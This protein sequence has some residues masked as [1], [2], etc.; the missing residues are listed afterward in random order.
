GARRHGNHGHFA[1]NQ[2]SHYCGKSIVVI[3]RPTILN[4]H[5][6]ALDVTAFTQA[7]PKR[8]Q[9]EGISFSRP[10]ADV[11]DHRHWLLRARRQRPR[12]SAAEQRD[13]V[14]AL[15][16]ITSSARPSSGSG[17]VMPSAFAVLR[18]R[19]SSTLV[20]CRTGKSAGLSP[21]RMRPV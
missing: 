21:L 20:D 17:K 19:I 9:P 7:L 3:L 1:T 8:G 18:L 15:H 5:V 13:E 2:L 11:S 6:P 12:G 14:A 16:S 10:S 4:R